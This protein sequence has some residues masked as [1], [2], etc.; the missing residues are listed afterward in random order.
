[1]FPEGDKT[2]FLMWQQQQQ[3]VA[4]EQGTHITFSG[5]TD[6]AVGFP[7]PIP[8]LLY[9]SPCDAYAIAEE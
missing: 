4:L 1:M 5:G 9:Y 6:S 7:Y 2:A 8:P 3:M